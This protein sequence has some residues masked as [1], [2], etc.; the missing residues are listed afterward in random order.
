[1]SLIVTSMLCIKRTLPKAGPLINISMLYIKKTLPKAE[2]EALTRWE[3]DRKREVEEAQRKLFG[4]KAQRDAAD[5]AYWAQKARERQQ[6]DALRNTTAHLPSVKDVT[7]EPPK[8]DPYAHLDYDERQAMLAREAAAQEKIKELG[9]RV[10]PAYNKGGYVL[11][12][13][14]MLEGMK[15][16]SHRRR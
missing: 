15:T 10:A 2:R 8:P 14:G 13:D 16:G 3:A 4:T 7:Y 1:M 6:L 5:A 9:N 11:Y 12:T